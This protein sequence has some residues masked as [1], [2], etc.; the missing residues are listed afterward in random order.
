VPTVDVVVDSPVVRS[1]RVEQIAGMFDVPLAE[2]SGE[3]F[4]VELPDASEEL[5]GGEWTVG[6]IVGPSGSGKSTVARAA[7]GSAFR[8]KPLVWP[9]GRSVLDGF[10]DGLSIRD[11]TAC[12]TMVGF[13]SPPAWVRPHA[14][15]STGQRFRSD[16]ARLLLDP[17]PDSGGLLAVDEFTSVVDRT[18][19]QIASAACAKAVRSGR[20][21]CRRF[22][23]VSCH[24]DILDWLEPDWVLDMADRRLERGR[25]RCRPE[26]RLEIGRCSSAAWPLFRDHHYLSHSLHQAATCYL[27]TWRDQPVGF[28][29]VLPMMGFKG[30]SRVSRIVTLPD[31][32]G[33]GIGKAVLDWL[34]AEY[35]RQGRSL[36]IRTG[37]PAMIAG[38]KRARCWRAVSF[39][40]QGGKQHKGFM[41]RGRKV[42]PAGSTGRAVATFR[43]VG[44]QPQGPEH[45]VQGVLAG[46]GPP[47]NP[48]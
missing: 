17:A 14:A 29:A 33:V 27:A 23:A 9:T 34:G 39:M 1:F 10:P 7:Y 13:S 24:Y 6:A 37:H 8:D 11:I 38:L 40:P 28:A 31:F 18:V 26:I 25:P 15:L 35:R 22:V 19:G 2:R 5:S 46:L 3:R 43:Y 16:L 41:P 4:Q 21:P 45:P 12:M 36:S 44:L 32:Q 30:Q 20:L 48:A 42:I 47:A